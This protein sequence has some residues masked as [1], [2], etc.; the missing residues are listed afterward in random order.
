MLSRSANCRNWFQVTS[1]LSQSVIPHPR[2]LHR[3]PIQDAKKA[4][5][6]DMGGVILPSP[7]S[8]AQSKGFRRDW[9]VRNVHFSEWEAENGFDAGSMFAAIKHNSH[10][11]AWARLERGELSLEEFYEPFA[12]E[13]SAMRGSGDKVKCVMS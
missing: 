6:F 1:R 5:I 9:S 10:T 12:R 13:V 7:F 2:Y 11:G 3:S 4:V 8:A